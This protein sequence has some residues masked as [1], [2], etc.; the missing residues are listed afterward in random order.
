[1]QSANGMAKWGD[2]YVAPLPTQRRSSYT[3]REVGHLLFRAENVNL[4]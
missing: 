1:M 2:S 3:I 4:Q